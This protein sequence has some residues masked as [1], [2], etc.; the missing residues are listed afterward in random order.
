M[1][2]SVM[3][4]D[5]EADVEPL[6]MQRFR[7][8]VKS[9][10]F[11]FHF[12][13][14]GEAALEWLETPAAADLVLILSDINMPGMTGLEL[15]KRIKERRPQL[16]VIMITAYDDEL[17]QRRAKESGADDYVTKPLD[18]DLLRRKIMDWEI[19]HYGHDEDKRSH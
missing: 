2:L 15:L 5:D 9:G 10:R 11:S 18:F 7:K 19:S 12:E 14:S 1:S 16:P 8:E 17:N 4:V 13:F 3:I 6:F